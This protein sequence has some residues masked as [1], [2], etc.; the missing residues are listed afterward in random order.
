VKRSWKFH[1]VPETLD[2]LKA[3][4]KCLLDEF[5]Q[6]EKAFLIK[7]L[8]ASGGNITRAAEKV[9][10]QRSNLSALMKKHKLSVDNL[11]S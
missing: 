6:A 4:K 7:A 11:E 5:G 3:F 1:S 9:G 2:E 10:M 8:K